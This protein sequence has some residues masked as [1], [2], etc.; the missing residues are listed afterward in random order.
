MH[1][2]KQSI[3]DAWAQISQDVIKKLYDTIPNRIFATI[4]ANGGFTKY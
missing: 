1:E 4:C 3:L 2:S